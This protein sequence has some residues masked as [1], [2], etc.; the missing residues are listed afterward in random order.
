MS[1]QVQNQQSQISLTSPAWQLQRKCDC[2]THTIADSKCDSCKKS[3]QLQRSAEHATP[4]EQIPSTVHNVLRSA[5]RPLDASTRNFFEPRFGQDFSR[6]R[7]HTDQRATESAVAVNARAYVAGDNLVVSN[8]HYQPNTHEGRKLLAHELAHVVQNGSS[9]HFANSSQTAIS[10]PND[11][12]EIAADRAAEVAMSNSGESA[13]AAATAA[14]SSPGIHRTLDDPLRFRQT[15]E[16]MFVSA[17]STGGGKLKNWEDPDPAKNA[18]GTAETLFK[19]AKTN[20]KQ[21]IK[22]NPGAAGGT[23]KVQTTE[24]DLD[25][26]AVDINQQLR[27]KYPFIKTSVS[28]TQVESA[29]NLMGPS[30][31][32]DQDYLR[33]WMANRLPKFSDIEDYS[34]SET[35]PRL[36]ALLD[37]LLAD[38]DIGADLKIMASRQGGFQRG[39][40]TKREIFIHEAI[41]PNKRKK[42]LFHELTHFYANDKYREWVKSTTNE[43]WYNEGFT[44][45]LAR[46]AM[47]APV[48]KLATEYQDRVDSIK[49]QVAVN[50]PDDD[51]ARAYFLGEVWRI[52]TKSKISRREVG[53]QLGLSETATDDEEKKA[54]RTGPGINQTVVP[55]QR[56]RFMNLGFDQ[57]TPKPEHVTFFRD[58]KKE[59][60]D[61]APASGVVFEGHASTAGT[62]Q[63]NMNLSLGRAR[64]FY[65]M[66]R[67]EG[68]ASNRLIKVNDPPHFGE[69]KTTAEEEDPATR[70]F[71]RRVEMQVKPVANQP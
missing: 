12:S 37:K 8:K 16:S 29:V 56:Y 50:V 2:G 45:Y 46:K 49:T 65:Q 35:D 66:A 14:K 17:P 43:R 70:A 27:A 36:I 9:S 68:L 71:N 1:K 32:T 44:E 23:L 4:V 24:A 51:I 38:S 5:G 30:I 40:G 3:S 53:A 42:T 41:D 31:T 34:I 21:F 63:Y 57:Q 25:T 18:V 22:Q 58:V 15:H 10:N 67:N 52:E 62:P 33:Q 11:A 13:H 55:G 6:V 48:L 64:A 54:S 59:V 39:E 28:N 20:I 61:P 26:D 69:T 7:L 19:Q 47:P 60:L